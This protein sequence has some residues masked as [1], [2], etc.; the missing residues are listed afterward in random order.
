MNRPLYWVVLGGGEPT[1]HP[2]LFDLIEMLHQKL[3]KRL[4]NV[5][6]ITNGSR[7]ET[8]YE[9]LAELS[10]SLYF[11]MTISIHTDYVNLSNI[12]HILELIE[13][14]S[15]N[16]TM[17]FSLMFNPDKRELVHEIY[18]IMYEYR[19]KYRFTMSIFTLRDGD[20][21]DSRYTPEDFAWQKQAIKEFNDLARATADKIPMT[22]RLGKN[23]TELW[24]YIIRDVEE[25]NGEIKT[26]RAGNRSV[27][28]AA[29]LYKFRDM[30]C[31]AS[32]SVL[33]IK[34]DGS[35]RGMVCSDDPL[36]YNLYEKNCFDSIRDKLIHPVKC[37]HNICGCGVNDKLPKFALE[38]AAKKFV[39]FA[40]GRQ[41]ALFDEYLGIAKK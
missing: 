24:G 8:F 14:L 26:V 11:I 30:Y 40:Q 4:N 18:G 20:S 1:T 15:G 3:G 5:R 12:S 41:S 10:K 7:N 34:P 28:L 32:S 37:K 16:V 2:H 36:V 39:E 13:N 23:W 27:E 38:E 33:H 6:I 19:K 31:I 17:D 22:K 29:G 21:V 35:C 9:K 25:A